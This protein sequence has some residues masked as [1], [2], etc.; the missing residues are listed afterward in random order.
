[1]FEEILWVVL[2]FAPTLA[3]LQA[4]DKK[5]MKKAASKDGEHL[6]EAEA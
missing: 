5:M 1:M 2:G 3:A 4:V 6:L